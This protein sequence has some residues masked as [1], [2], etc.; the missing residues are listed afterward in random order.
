MTRMRETHKLIRTRLQDHVRETEE[1]VYLARKCNYSQLHKK[2]LLIV[3]RHPFILS[4]I[5]RQ[6]T[7]IDPTGLLVILQLT[8]DRRHAPLL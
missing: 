5:P 6:S 2:L 3:I 4:A 1:K 7:A 8:H